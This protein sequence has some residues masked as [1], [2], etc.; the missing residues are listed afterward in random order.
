MNNFPLS[1][2]GDAYGKVTCER[3][4]KWKR[5]DQPFQDYDLWYVWRGEGWLVLNGEERPITQNQCYLFRP[6]DR[7]DAWH[8]PDRPLVVTYIH[9]TSEG[10]R[11]WLSSLPSRFEL[12]SPFAFEVYLERLVHA[13]TCR[14][15]RYEEETDMLLRLLLLGLE[16]ESLSGDKVT[17]HGRNSHL[18][19][20]NMIAASIRENPGQVGS[21]ADLAKQ[22]FLSP[23]YF[24][25]KF[26]ETMG[27][28]IESYII[29]K[30]IER[31]ELLLSQHGMTV[32]E[33]ADALGY[34]NIYYFSKQFKKVRGY[35]PSRAG[36]RGTNN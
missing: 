29:E 1:I 13:M 27:Q 4:W 25:M 32:G 30:R 33:V 20:M 14:E 28:T 18:D 34:Q 21:I 5:S 17:G 35:S 31:A 16:R 7:V 9:F 10:G 2:S 12:R 19:T 26:R 23:R 15:H 22:A 36:G 24:S 3:G 8:N 6:G 11:S